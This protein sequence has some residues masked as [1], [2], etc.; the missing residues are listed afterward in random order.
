LVVVRFYF[1][2]LVFIPLFSFSQTV[3]VNGSVSDRFG[4]LLPLASMIILPDSVILNADIDGHFSVSFSPGLKQFNLS[5]TGYQSLQMTVEVLKDTLLS[6]ILTP[7]I[8][9]LQTVVIEEQRFSNEDLLLATS[10]GT[11]RIT[12]DDINKMPVFMGEADVI[13][14][15]QLLPGTVR[16]VEGSS[17]LFVR[18]GAADQ[19]LVL[20][21]GAPIYNS[22]HL[23]GFLSVFNPDALEQV[24]AING[25]FPASFG[26]RLSSVMNV[27]TKS[28]IPEKTN[29]SGGVGLL[30]SHLFVEQ[31]LIKDK[32]SVWV[33]GRRTYIDKVMKVIDEKLPYYF[34]DLNGKFIYHPTPNDEIQLSHYGGEDVLDF[35]RDKN[36]DGVGLIFSYASATSSQ[37]AR[38]TH[39]VEN[40][41]SNDLSLIHTAYNYRIHHGFEGDTVVAYSN[42]E[43]F[44]GKYSLTKDSVWGSDTKITVG[45]EMIHH[46]VSPNVINSKGN[47]SELIGNSSSVGGKLANEAA[48]FFQQEWSLTDR[49]R[50][51]TGVR[52]SMVAVQNKNYFFTEPRFSARYQFPNESAVKFNYSRMVQY[53]HRISNTSVST[54][55]DIWYP[56]T[57]S[58]R[59]Q[60]SHQV[61]TAWQ[62]FLPSNKLFLSVEGYY[63]SMDDLIG[64]EEGTNLFFNTDFESKLIQGEGRAYGLE[65]LV[66]KDVGKLSGWISY[67][68]SWSFRRYDEINNGEWFHARYDRRHNGAIVAQYSFAKRWALSGVWEFISG[69]RFTPVIG[70]YAMMSPTLS[71]VDLIPIYSD[72]NQVKLSD[73]H[74]LDLGI[75]FLSKPDQKFEWQWF[76][77][78]YNAYNRASP[79]GMMI[80]QDKNDGSLKYSQPGLFGLLPFISYQFKF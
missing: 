30:S 26:G 20:L 61:S 77:G 27:Q 72:V 21:D 57:E 12:M 51:N 68:L 34:Y 19:N 49:W 31:P 66:R 48:V 54:P 14:T 9:E 50:V 60:T 25:G 59:P 10:S 35:F 73:T 70:Q 4:E 22:S 80:E 1:L 6:F 55:T 42:I 44:G 71:G 23:F 67:T 79:M 45:M 18:G 28:L 36:N 8:D 76:L 69:A 29:V 24:E 33:A 17:D 15:L 37:S 78:V 74:R 40:G 56:V 53:M 3:T 43:D 38:W 41:W 5:Y 52:Q 11:T 63:K 65:F 16:G 64:Y 46:A 75:K 7:R 2:V 62:S 32:A 58:I 47:I 13:K 39:H